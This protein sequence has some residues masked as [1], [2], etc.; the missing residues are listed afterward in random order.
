MANGFDEKVFNK[1]DP[2]DLH[3]LVNSDEFNF[4]Y[5]GNSQ[6]R[7]GLDI[8]ANAWESLLRNMIR[9]L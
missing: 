3:P 9:L 7:K 6:W 2:T 4:V 5:V 1:D 8:L